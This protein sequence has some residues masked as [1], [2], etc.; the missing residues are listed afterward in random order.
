MESINKS[1]SFWLQTDY[2]AAAKKCKP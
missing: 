1:F 2:K